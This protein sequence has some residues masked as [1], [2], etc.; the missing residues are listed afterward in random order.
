MVE[1]VN[2]QRKLFIMFIN[3]KGILCQISHIS[4]DESRPCKRCVNRG[5]GDQCKGSYL[6]NF[7]NLF[8]HSIDPEGE[9][10]QRGR[11]KKY[12]KSESKER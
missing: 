11:K 1:H 4:C 9:R 7:Y 8:T 3:V 10:K 12:L 5:I 2:Q 6:S